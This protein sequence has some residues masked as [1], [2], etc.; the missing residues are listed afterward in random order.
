LFTTFDLLLLRGDRRMVFG[1]TTTCAVS[2]C[3]EPRSWRDALDTTLCDTVCQWLAKCQWF[4]PVSAANK[5]D[6]HN[7][8]EKLLKVALNTIDHKTFYLW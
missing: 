3:H 5:T 6:C 8:T 4:S 7:I 2:A 1:F